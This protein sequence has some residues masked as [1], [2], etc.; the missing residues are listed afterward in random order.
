MQLLQSKKTAN[1][2]VKINRVTTVVVSTAITDT[3]AVLDTK[4][5]IFNHSNY[6]LLVILTRV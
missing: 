6:K 2:Q 5:T 1:K 3:I 4:I